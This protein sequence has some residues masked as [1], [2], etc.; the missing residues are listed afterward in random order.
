MTIT[1]IEDAMIA[2]LESLELFDAVDSAGRPGEFDALTYPAASAMF[3]SERDLG[4]KSRRV[5]ELQFAVLVSAQNL[6]SEQAAAQDAYALIDAVRDA[7]HGQTLGAEDIEP[8]ACL[9]R[10][11]V[12]YQDGIITYQLTFQTRQAGPI[13]S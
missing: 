13:T 9:R 1:E 2:A 7:I 6:Q 4:V 8:F 3:L 12:G 5:S 10:E 11:L